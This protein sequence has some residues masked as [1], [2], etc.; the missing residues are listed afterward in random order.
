MWL[1]FLFYVLYFN[2]FLLNLL[3]SIL[4][5]GVQNYIQIVKT[6]A[7]FSVGQLISPPPYKLIYL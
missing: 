1:F 6:D 7:T 5:V 3:Q 4:I 2:I